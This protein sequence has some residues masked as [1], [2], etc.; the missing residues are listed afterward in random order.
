MAVVAPSPS[1]LPDSYEQ[2]IW[3]RQFPK[4]EEVRRHAVLQQPP[5]SWPPAPVLFPEL[6]LIVKYGGPTSIAEGQCLW[7]IRNLL[8]DR[9]PIPEVYGWIRDG[10]EIFIY[11]ELIRGST[12]EQRWDQ[13]SVEERLDLCDQLHPMIASLRD[14][15]PAPGESCIGSIASGRL[16]DILF[17]GYERRTFPESRYLLRLLHA[18]QMGQTIEKRNARDRSDAVSLPR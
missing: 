2:T 5:H 10:K 8:G 17:E 14:I 1:Q 6:T 18:T 13:L 16:Q 15:R 7:M 11:M 4:P 3:S 9:I 12:L